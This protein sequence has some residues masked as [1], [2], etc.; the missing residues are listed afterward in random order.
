MGQTISQRDG[1]EKFMIY[2]IIIG[3]IGAVAMSFYV[4]NGYRRSISGI[5]DPIQGPA[6]GLLHIKQG[7]YDVAVTLVNSYDIEGLV[8]HTRD[9]MSSDI[10]DQLSPCDIGLAWGNVAANNERYDLHWDHGNRFLELSCDAGVESAL[11]GRAYVDSHISNN[12]VIP[13]DMNICWQ[14]RSIHPGSHVRLK[15]YLVYVEGI[16]TKGDVFYWYSSLKRDDT[17]KG[18]CE[19]MYVTSVEWL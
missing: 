8:V 1:M 4:K 5:G 6:E 15:G 13:A 2:A 17:G 11:G 18:A 10:G 9:Y 19:V 14:L 3:I 16:S 12:H 7:G